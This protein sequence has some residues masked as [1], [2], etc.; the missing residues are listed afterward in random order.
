MT[1]SAHTIDTN[2]NWEADQRDEVIEYV[3]NRVTS[4]RKQL[5]NAPV[6]YANCKLRRDA[7]IRFYNY[8]IEKELAWLASE[9][10]E[11]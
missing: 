5:A 8:Q 9:G 11:F 3:K 10:I 7:I 1:T 2:A 6:R 4:M